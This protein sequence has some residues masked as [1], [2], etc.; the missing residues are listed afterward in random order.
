DP[1]SIRG[2]KL[3]R[4]VLSK[5][6][7]G[8]FQHLLPLKSY[9]KTQKPGAERR[10]QPLFSSGSTRSSNGIQP[11]LIRLLTIGSSP[12]RYFRPDCESPA[13]PSTLRECR[14]IC[15]LTRT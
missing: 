1:E 15:N 2:C 14:T 8:Y 9:P 4:S 12:G 13:W 5:E 6:D 10:A 11:V 3:Y 7:P